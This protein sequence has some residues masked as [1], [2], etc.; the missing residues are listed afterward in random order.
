MKNDCKKHIY[1]MLA[2]YVDV[3]ASMSPRIE[4]LRSLQMLGNTVCL[5]ATYKQHKIDFVIP[6]HLIDVCRNSAFARLSF[7]LKSI[8]AFWKL[9]KS[10]NISDNIFIIVDPNSIYGGLAIKFI[11]LIFRQYRLTL[12]FDIRTVPVELKGVKGALDY[13]LFWRIPLFFA[14]IFI[15]SCSFITQ[16]IR[17]FAGFSDDIGC[18]WSS[19]VN[20]DFFNPEKY[21][22]MPKKEFILFYHGVVTSNRGL[23]ETIS[24]VK[25]IKQNIPEIIFRVVGD[26]S[27]L[28]YLKK[29]TEKLDLKD[30]I[31]FRGF[32][33]HIM[34]PKFISETD[35]C[36]CP[37]PDI[38]WWR[39]SSPLKVL[40]YSAMG[41][42]CILT[43]IQP[44]LNLMQNMDGGVYWAGK[45]SPEEIAIVIK[46][47][48]RDKNR[49]P[50][51]G[52]MLRKL[53]EENTWKK[54][55]VILNNYWLKRCGN[56]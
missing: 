21:E 6:S 19:G 7:N 53:A 24:A 8:F 14:H 48:Y 17:Q 22:V 35:V 1:W 37:L 34:I 56:S 52:Q 28:L 31:D 33:K 2:S 38:P 40:E 27:D 16:Y 15:P 13:I 47:A 26:G 29:L 42:T 49:L 23:R 4:M 45:G 54:Q 3:K 5:V 55:A 25:L 32:A 18:V 36:I 43:E 50:D 20:T 11:S 9:L 46:Q 44:H 10:H 12:H 51:S 41:K 30:N 39:V